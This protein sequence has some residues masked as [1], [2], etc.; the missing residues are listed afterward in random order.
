MTYNPDIH[1]RRSIRLRGFD[2]SQ[3]G[4][5]FVTI[6]CDE[7][8][9]RFGSIEDGEMIMN[10]YGIIAYNEWWG[11]TERFDQVDMDIFQIMPNHIHGIIAIGVG[12]GASL[13][14]A[15]LLFG[16]MPFGLR[17]DA[18]IRAR[19]GARERGQGRALPLQIWVIL[20]VPINHWWRMKRCR[21]T[22]WNHG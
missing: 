2:Y 15:L 10:E 1:H 4:L 8:K 19:A 13:A 3:A 9:H 21:N 18:Q 17:T 14:D 16:R 5:Y 6:C 12:V 7:R 20:W 22:V 11:L